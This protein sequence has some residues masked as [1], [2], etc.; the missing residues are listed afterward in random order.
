MKTVAAI[1]DKFKTLRAN[2]KDVKDGA[3]SSGNSRK[4]WNFM[5]QMD[6]IFKDNPT[7]DPPHLRDSSSSDH[8]SDLDNESSLVRC[9]CCCVLGVTIRIS[10]C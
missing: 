8:H 9:C 3:K 7:I 6:I 2:Y 10:F 4:P 1:I 5:E